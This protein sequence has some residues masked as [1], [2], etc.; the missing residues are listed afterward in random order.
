MCV[1][2][3]VVVV[4]TVAVVTVPVVIV[5]AVVVVFVARLF[6]RERNSKTVAAVAAIE[7]LVALATFL[8]DVVASHPLPL[9]L[10]MLIVVGFVVCCCT[11][12]SCC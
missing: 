12:C 6:H 3:I 10:L 2:V 4:V 9:Q 7:L 5:I 11:A 8:I 1:Y